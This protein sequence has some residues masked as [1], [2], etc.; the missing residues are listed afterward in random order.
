MCAGRYTSISHRCALIYSDALYYCAEYAELVVP[1]SN[2]SHI[3]ARLEG[4][5][6]KRS[7]LS[8]HRPIRTHCSKTSV[9]EIRKTQGG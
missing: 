8:L 1:P 6:L 5:E 2:T 4:E 7:R 3:N 9:L